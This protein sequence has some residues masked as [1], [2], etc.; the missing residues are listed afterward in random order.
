MGL[1]QS[2]VEDREASSGDFAHIFCPQNCNWDCG[3]AVVRMVHRWAGHLDYEPPE[4]L[5]NIGSPLWTIDLMQEI[6]RT[7]TL[8]CKMYTL[9]AAICDHHRELSWYEANN[10]K[11]FGRI[12]NLFEKSIA[13]KWPVIEVLQD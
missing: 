1:S 12:S 13:E 9:S 6:L 8:Q 4:D 3:I 10:T 2:N 7:K 5:V 11:D